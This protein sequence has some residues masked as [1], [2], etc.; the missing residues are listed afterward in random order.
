MGVHRA[1]MIFKSAPQRHFFC[2]IFEE[3]AIMWKKYVKVE[4]DM[5]FKAKTVK[6]DGSTDQYVNLWT[7]FCVWTSLFDRFIAVIRMSLK[8]RSIKRTCKHLQS[9]IHRG[10]EQLTT[11]VFSSTLILLKHTFCVNRTVSGTL[12]L[13]HPSLLP[14]SICLPLSPPKHTLILWMCFKLIMSP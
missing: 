11:A 6:T 9:F 10:R 7:H 2:W 14:P 12:I 3:V 5:R 13:Y 8:S 4:L 1:F